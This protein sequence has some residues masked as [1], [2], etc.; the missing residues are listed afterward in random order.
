MFILATE[1]LEKE[2]PAIRK[3]YEEALKE[4]RHPCMQ[5][6]VHTMD[7]T[8]ITLELKVLLD[9]Y[10]RTNPDTQALMR[11]LEDAGEI[12]VAMLIDNN[13]PW[14]SSVARRPK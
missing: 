6:I 3:G 5:L 8:C 9:V 2:T 12:P 13:T 7:E 4:S 1:T 10:E 11:E 14:M